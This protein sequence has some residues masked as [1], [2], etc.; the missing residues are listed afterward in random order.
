MENQPQSTSKSLVIIP[1]EDYENI[2][3]FKGKIFEN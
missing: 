3:D 2:D 1:Q